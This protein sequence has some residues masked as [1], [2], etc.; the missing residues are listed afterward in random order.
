MA[1]RSD[2]REDMNK[3]PNIQITAKQIRFLLSAKKV[4]AIQRLSVPNGVPVMYRGY[5]SMPLD[6]ERKYPW[7]WGTMTA[8][9]ELKVFKRWIELGYKLP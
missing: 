6:E 5:Y 8:A 4:W 7:G 9:A 2:N 3:D 1:A